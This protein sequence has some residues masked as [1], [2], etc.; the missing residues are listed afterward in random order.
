MMNK[1]YIVLFVGL[2]LIS[3]CDFL[4]EP[5]PTNS[6]DVGKGLQSL[7]DYQNMLYG[8]YNYHQ[9]VAAQFVAANDFMTDDVVW[10]GTFVN[11]SEIAAR[12]I[13]ASNSTA[14]T[15]WNAA[16][17]VINNANIII[18]QSVGSPQNVPQADLDDVIAQAYFMRAF[19]Y[20]NLVQLYAKPWGATSDNSHPGVPL[21]LEPVSD[22]ADF[23]SLSRSTVAQ[24]Y[25]QIADDLIEASGKIKNETAA[26]ATNGAV[27]ALQARIAAIQS[28]WPAAYTLS[29]EVIDDYGYSL[30]SDV[31]T[32]FTQKLSDESIFEIV[33]TIDDAAGGRD[34]SITALYHTQ[35][36]AGAQ[37]AGSYKQ[38]VKDIITAGQ[39]S[40]LAAVNQEAADARV[41]ELLYSTEENPQSVDDYISS[42]KYND[43]ASYADNIPVLRLSEMI[44]IRA[45][46]GAEL[47]DVNQESIDLINSLRT[48]AISVADNSGGAGDQSL[49]EYKMADFGNKQ[50][51]ID[52]VLLEGRVELAFEGLRKMNLQ[53]RHLDVR[54]LSWDSDKLVM[55]IP[56]SQTDSDPSV[57]PNP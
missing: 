12:D 40:A 39:A 33:N 14:A 52:A 28:D 42:A 22:S 24:V 32:Y 9:N 51:L 26:F 8:A 6:I 29:G 27:K 16:Y 1:K 57:D 2:F 23:E 56:L 20:Y 4:N 55:P 18:N 44:L 49:I 50:D 37:L 21:K 38:A 34:N 15:L 41:T 35:V 17:Q 7:N 11:F 53:R 47:N 36:R 19:S 46:A 54:G 31:T 45:E 43:I 5:S 3:S 13:P 48:R 30:S 10:A 25:Q